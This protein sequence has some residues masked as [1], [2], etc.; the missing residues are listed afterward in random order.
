MYI[1]LDIG[2]S[3]AK[4]ALIGAD[5]RVIASHH[6]SY[7][8]CNTAGGYR[9]LD[10]SRVWEAACA[11]IAGA[12][13][14][15]EALS[16]TV[17]SLGEAI[18][19]VDQGGQPLCAG[20]TGTDVRGQAEFDELIRLAGEE[21]LIRRT[22][23]NLSVIYS[24]NKILWLMRHQPQVY[25]RAYKILTFQD[26]II[27][28]LTGE[29]VIDR[30][31]ACRT[32]LMDEGTNDWSAEMLKLTGIDS[33]KLSRIVPAGT[34]AG[35]LRKDAAARLGLP[36]GV[37]VVAGTHD[38][39]CNALGSGVVGAG[40]CANTVGTSEGLTAVLE[41]DWLNAES[42]GR[43]QISREPFAV[44][45]LYNT[46]A[47]NNTSGVML[48]W[49][50]LQMVQEMP[51]ERLLDTFAKLNASMPET[52]T[53]LLALPHFSGAATPY[54]DPFSRGAV[55]GM[56][57]DTTREEIY[58]ALMEG[59]NYELLLIL[60]SLR[61][62]GLK[63][64]QLVATGGALSPQLLQVKADILDMPVHTVGSR[65]TGT[66][67][68]AMLGAVA[69]GHCGSLREAAERM[70]TAGPVYE[71]IEGN[72]RVYRERMALYRGLY[73]ALKDLNRQL[74]GG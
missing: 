63:S 66:L 12:A 15:K 1:G 13:G 34:I 8:F 7:G 37:R 27:Y 52:P 2:T 71:P 61:Q 62:A 46:V 6:E 14:G 51:K 26:Y 38:H 64:T 49:F 20:I 19:P 48:R 25:E 41:K 3:G 74:S 33:G 69:L 56:T 67:G 57:L 53:R 9:E 10:A 60:E 16:I 23:Q 17:S 29:A 73:P 44:D 43:C 35:T 54:M 58:K 24:A 21:T 68:G 5:G 72:A 70:V 45:G 47:W 18:V 22:G 36:E 30:S 32:L 31:M 4:A 50:A 11:C 42:I 39:I 65:D 28:R 55:I 40:D 59:A